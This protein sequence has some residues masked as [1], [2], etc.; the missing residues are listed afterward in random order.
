M[1]DNAQ[2][3]QSANETFLTQLTSEIKMAAAS[4]PSTSGIK[5]TPTNNKE[6]ER[7]RPSTIEEGIVVLL[8]AVIKDNSDETFLLSSV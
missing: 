2:N 1:K 3:N 7:I 5:Q 8:F 4:I 6:E